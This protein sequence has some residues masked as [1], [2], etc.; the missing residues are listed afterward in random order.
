MIQTNI[1]ALSRAFSLPRATRWTSALLIALALLPSLPV[2]AQDVEEAPGAEAT[3]GPHHLG[4][5][6]ASVP[7][8]FPLF[9]YDEGRPGALAPMLHS[10]RDAKA[11]Y[12]ETGWR[13]VFAQIHGLHEAF[14]GNVAQGHAIFDAGMG[15][16]PAVTIPADIAARPLKPAASAILDA[17]CSRQ[18]VMINESHHVSQHRAFTH[19]LLTLLYDDGFRY[20]AAEVLNAS[21]APEA[22]VSNL[23]EQVR[24]DDPVTTELM[25]TAHA[26][27]YHLVAYD[28]NTGNGFEERERTQA[29]NIAAV[30][31]QDSTARV[32]V[33]A[34]PGHINEEETSTGHTYM[35]HYFRDRTGI[36]P[37]TID[38]T[39]L[40]E[41]GTQKHEESLYRAVTSAQ[42]VRDPSTG[43]HLASFVSRGATTADMYVLHPRT[44]YV[45]GRP[46]WLVR[47]EAR[48]RPAPID[49]IP[50]PRLAF[51]DA[52]AVDAGIHCSTS[53]SEPAPTDAFS[54][55]LIEAYDAA[56]PYIRLMDRVEWH[57]DATH[58]A[59]VLPPG[60][61]LAR[62][63]SFDGTCLGT[64][65]LSVPRSQSTAK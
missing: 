36:D 48:F 45:A 63:T 39:T 21:V 11:T 55:V 50:H 4:V 44:E 34:G 25:H 17:A 3:G 19:S 22:D 59:L 23:D 13:S 29:R 54:S 37:L 61:F 14:A 38:Q 49:R 16:P 28:I 10:V 53:E 9:R 43:M 18:V 2:A 35:A 32:V 1:W 65:S 8:P 40:M 56:T 46:H 24:D 20:L 26:L 60:E 30:I 47:G 6:G 41:R 64:V 31:E 5:D 12:M 62:Y 27:G 7:P 33:L 15:T 58:P 52:D 57:L 42:P 51:H